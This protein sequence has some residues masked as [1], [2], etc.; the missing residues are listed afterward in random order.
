MP[1]IETQHDEDPSLPVLATKRVP[2]PVK[3]PFTAYSHAHDLLAVVTERSEVSIFRIVSG[4]LA[5]AIRRGKDSEVHVTALAWKADGGCLGVGW[6]DGTYEIYDGGSGR[7]VHT[8]YINGSES[9]DSDEWSLYL[10]SHGRGKASASSETARKAQGRADIFGW[11][12]HEVGSKRV[13]RDVSEDFTTDDW[14]DDADQ[15]ILDGT[16]TKTNGTGMMDLPRA[17]ATLDVTKVLPR[18]AA[19]PVANTVAHLPFRPG[20][21]GIKYATQAATDAVFDTLKEP[22]PSLVESLIVAH[23]DGTVEV[24]VDET[25][26]IGSLKIQGRP[27]MHA[28]HPNS[29]SHVVLNRAEGESFQLSYIDLPLSTFSGAVLHVIA[30]NTKRI[31]SQL[32][33]I[34]YTLRCIEH[35]Y[36]SGVELPK[37]Y[38]DLLEEPSEMDA[39][40]DPVF[41]LYH[42]AMTGTG[43]K[44]LLEWL[45][46]MVK[47]TGLK[48]WEPNVNAMYLNMSNHI[49][50]NLIPALDRLTVAITT[51]RGYARL[52]DG[53]SKFDVP[54][55]LFSNILEHVDSLRL[56]A[57]RMQLIIM[58]EAVHFRAFIK[59]LRMQLDIAIAGPGSQSAL[60]TEEREVP[61]MN[62]ALI[63]G[64]IKDT[65]KKSD[66]AVHIL[67]RPGME[68]PFD[69]KKMYAISQVKDMGYERSKEA[70]LR[71]ETLKDKGE[72][73]MKDVEDPWALLNIPA[74]AA[75]LVGSVRIALQ[76]ITEWQ[77]RMLVPPTNI[78]FNI[79]KDTTIA[80]MIHVPIPGRENEIESTETQLL[81]LNPST[82]NQLEII[83][84]TRTP[85]TSTNVNLRRTSNNAPPPAPKQTSSQH[86]FPPGTILDAKWIPHESSTFL[87]LF[88]NSE[89]DN[90]NQVS[91]IRHRILANQLS[92]EVLHLFPVAFKAEKLLIGGRK[93]KVLCVVFGNR[94]REWR[95]LDLE[96]ARSQSR[97]GEQDEELMEMEEQF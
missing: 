35:D 73:T 70:L 37:R 88:R 90:A 53:S 74:L 54:P 62:Y 21:D 26:K 45:T 3:F 27:T 89:G 58:T 50:I 43:S 55:Q 30:S 76:R 91:V 25:V 23:D 83:S 69:M 59:W 47:D 28:A 81:A 65:L 97:G 85:T 42:L 44:H 14:Y 67:N 31:Q 5:F 6:S 87:S 95:V 51:L 56:V 9:E 40:P 79:E 77:S 4:Q 82:P 68:G 60:E 2:E 36:K 71:L 61:G 8:T 10:S 19:V 48:R 15:E 20:P 78:P 49:L 11:M 12:G 63:M 96:A 29:P 18:L 46:D 75:V 57:Q 86:N 7:S 1:A 64:Y 92:S 84:L 33:Y 80:D 22:D 72:F 39:N 52:Y 24:L 41:N 34:T 16:G 13:R 66:L 94:G 93:G 38:I 17:I 32:D